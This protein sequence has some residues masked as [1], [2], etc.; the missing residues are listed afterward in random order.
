MNE[1][2]V[3]RRFNIRGEDGNDLAVSECI[4]RLSVVVSIHQNDD[5]GRIATVSLNKEQWD[6]FCDLKYTVDVEKVNTVPVAK[7]GEVTEAKA[8][9]AGGEGQGDAADNF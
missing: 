1:K 2:I 5:K 9:Y 7:P 6:A 3:T 4:E 8:E